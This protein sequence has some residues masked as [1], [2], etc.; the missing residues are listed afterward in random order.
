MFG[1]LTDILLALTGGAIG[2]Q[3]PAVYARYTHEVGARIRQA[4]EGVDALTAYAERHGMAVHEALDRLRAKG[5]VAEA[6]YTDLHETYSTLVRLE[7]AHTALTNAGPLTRPFV[8]AR[9]FDPAIAEA[10]VSDFTPALPLTGAG[11]AYALAGAG[12]LLLMGR[13]V[14]MLGARIARRLRA[15]RP[16]KAQPSTPTHGPDGA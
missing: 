5:G 11:A 15:A 6:A 4:R 9:H 1:R 2:A 10:A 14:R 12:A 3:A 7:P 8:L 16:R 13:G